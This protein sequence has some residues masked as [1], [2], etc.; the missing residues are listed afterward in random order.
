MCSLAEKTAVARKR[1]SEHVP[2]A[3]DIN[4]IIDEM[5]DAVPCQ[6]LSA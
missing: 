5:L 3:T 6:I 2:A 1:L 4:E